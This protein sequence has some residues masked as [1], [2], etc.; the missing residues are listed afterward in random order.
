[1]RHVTKGK[2]FSRKKEILHTI[3]AQNFNTKQWYICTKNARGFT[4]EEKRRLLTELPNSD[5]QRR[6]FKTCTITLCT[7][8]QL[9]S[10]CTSIPIFTSLS[11]I[12]TI[13]TSLKP[14]NPQV[15]LVMVEESLGKIECLT[16]SITTPLVMKE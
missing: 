9:S 4:T 3:A 2:S 10:T 1:M 7:M 14:T 5:T 6:T 13:E 15:L 11:K 8:L 12:L 16:K